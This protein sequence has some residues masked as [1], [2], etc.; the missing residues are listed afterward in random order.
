MSQQEKRKI[1]FAVLLHI[2]NIKSYL[3]HLCAFSILV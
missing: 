3:A 2:Q 1:K